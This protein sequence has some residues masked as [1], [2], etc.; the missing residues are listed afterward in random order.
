M[1]D[2]EA[3]FF[4]L[5]RQGLWG[6]EPEEWDGTELTGIEWCRLIDMGHMQAVSGFLMDGMAHCKLRPAGELWGK[7][8]AR[9]VYMERIN[10]HIAN[11]G[12]AWIERLEEAGLEAEIFKG[13]SVAHWYDRPM[14][15]SYG[16]LDIVVTG[17]WD[18]LEQV[19]Q[20][21]RMDYRWEHDDIVLRERDVMVEF[22]RQREYLYNPVAHR[23]LTRMLQADR[24]GQELY[25][26]CLILHMRRHVLTY[27]I[28][29]KQVCDVAAML[30][31]ASLDQGRLAWILR[32]LHMVRFSRVLFGFIDVYIK[33][34]REFPLPPLYDNRM[35]L[36]RRIIWKDGYLLKME[37]ERYA[38][39]KHTAVARIAGN[40]IFWLKRSCS[41][42]GLMPAEACCFPLYMMLRRL[43]GLK[44]L[45]K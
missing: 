21:W 40:G 25:L 28:G 44:R 7:C 24:E 31:N 37:R 2:C 23:R 13:P 45:K 19:L 11:E 5:L 30:R 4:Y 20:E 1:K 14:H 22:H 6:E 35:Q 17:G 16:D 18:R 3:W 12:T 10:T 33:G 39:N 8:I 41:L 43:R 38:E 27:G 32:R 9:L 34:V 29:L 42:F 36:L 15:R 26:A